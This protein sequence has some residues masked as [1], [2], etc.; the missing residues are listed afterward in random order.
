M[1]VRSRNAGSCRGN[2]IGLQRVPRLATFSVFVPSTRPVCN[3]VPG[4]SIGVP[5]LLLDQVSLLSR[6]QCIPA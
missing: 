2:F 3:V 5:V 1:L 4:F 6:P